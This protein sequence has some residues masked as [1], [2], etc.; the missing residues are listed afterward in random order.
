VLPDPVTRYRRV[1]I[2]F[3]TP[4]LGDMSNDGLLVQVNESNKVVDVIDPFNFSA[5]QRSLLEE[6]EGTF[7]TNY[8]SPLLRSGKGDAEL[9]ARFERFVREEG[10]AVAFMRR[11]SRRDRRRSLLGVCFW[12]V[13]RHHVSDTDSW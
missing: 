6:N 4:A 9:T 7:L 5:T 3:S 10:I 2:T 12:N 8:S 11:S 13:C 1:Y